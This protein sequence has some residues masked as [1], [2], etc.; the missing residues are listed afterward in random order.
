MSNDKP[1]FWAN[2]INA[3]VK[4]P[5]STL[6]ESGWRYGDIPTASN[7]NW[8][9]NQIQKDLHHAKAEI[10]QLKEKIDT[11]LKALDKEI[12]SIKGTA[13]KIKETAD[14]SMNEARINRK[15]G[16]AS[17]ENLQALFTELNELMVELKD[18]NLSLK[19]RFFRLKD[20]FDLIDE[21]GV[22]ARYSMD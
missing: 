9:F 4:E 16:Y 17:I 22:V 11:S 19:S 18:N 12:L 20:E 2:G 15:Y 3:N 10:S 7:F 6:M 21:K 5:H 8:L 13:S 14:R 1:I